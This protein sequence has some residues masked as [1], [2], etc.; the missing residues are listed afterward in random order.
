MPHP[1]TADRLRAVLD[2]SIVSGRF[3]WKATGNR[4]GCVR[5]SDGYRV[6][7]L[8]GVLH[9]A[10]RLAVLWVTGSWPA[11]FVDH[12]NVS[13]DCNAWHNLREAGKAQNG[14]NR[15]AD[16]DSVTG[17]KGVSKNRKGFQGRVTKNGTT[18]RAGTY[19][20]PEEAY[21]AVCRLR[22]ELHGSFANHG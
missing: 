3:Y 16:R 19:A 4:A 8:D 20:T 21:T 12:D 9:L 17:F 13:K 5:T 1:L 15:G 18:Y 11:A 7:R 22:N 2:Y 10:H 6:I 14:W